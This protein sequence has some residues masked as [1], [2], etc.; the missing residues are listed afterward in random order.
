[1]TENPDKQELNSGGPPLEEEITEKQSRIILEIS[2]DGMEAYLI[3]KFLPTESIV[4]EED[5][6][7]VLQEGNV[8]YGVFEEVTRTA[9]NPER[10]GS[11]VLAAIG[12]PPVDGKD[13]VIHFNHQSRVTG[14]AP[15]QL[16]DGRIDFYNLYLITCV[17]PGDV[18]A[19]LE[20]ATLGQPGCTVTGETIPAKD[21]KP[22]KLTPGKNVKLSDDKHEVIATVAGHVIINGNTV[23]VSPIYQVNGDVD[24]NTGNI[25]FNGSVVITGNISE[26]FRVVADGNV[27]VLN[28]I[29][30][31]FVDCT[32]E[33]RVKNG[34]V[35]KNKAV[36]KAGGS[37]ITRFIENAFVESGMDVMV[38]EAIM[39]SKVSASGC[40]NVSGKGVIVGGAVRAGQQI[41]CRIVGSNLATA[42]ELEAGISPGLR[43][44]YNRLLKEKQS[45][46]ADHLKSCQIINYL[47]NIRLAKGELSQEQVDIL[48]RVSKS[49]ASLT[50]ELEEL[51]NTLQRTEALILRSG[52]GRI[53]VE[54]VIHPGVKITIGS[55]NL[56]VRDDYKS[57]SFTRDECGISISPIR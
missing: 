49:Q 29:S 42:T 41:T 12:S 38:S 27:E 7:R 16:S 3:M 15:K 4:S 44:E 24:F 28:I 31:G 8:V 50:Q 20:D 2:P 57:V 37:V 54:D 14:G 48:V 6:M 13:A 51:K 18:L 22:A 1:M 39:H 26:G 23:N 34:I 5:I 19:V 43:Q 40:V 32:G 36:I 47:R 46:E 17:E 55:D 53:N 30:G 35:G 9:L 33:L 45:K 52:H 10:W 25:L 11:P 56:F 21:G